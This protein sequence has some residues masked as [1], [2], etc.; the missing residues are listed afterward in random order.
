MVLKLILM[1]TMNESSGGSW[2]EIIQELKY[3]YGINL[4]TSYF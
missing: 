4:V 2:H 3:I 1:M